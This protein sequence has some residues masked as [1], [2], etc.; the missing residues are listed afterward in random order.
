MGLGPA[1]FFR[2]DSKAF[3]G[4]V[5]HCFSAPNVGLGASACLISSGRSTREGAKR[6]NA[7]QGAPARPVSFCGGPNAADRTLTE[8]CLASGHANVAVC[9]EAREDQTLAY[10]RSTFSRD[11]PLLETTRRHVDQRPVINICV[12]SVACT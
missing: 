11:G 4:S 1:L 7:G 10:V 2:Q 9:S 6:S 3:F 5:L 8:H 12:S